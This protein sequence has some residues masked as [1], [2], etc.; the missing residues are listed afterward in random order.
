MKCDCCYSCMRSDSISGCVK[1]TNFL[2]KYFPVIKMRKIRK[3]LDK[4]VT[5][6][7]GDLFKAMNL[8]SINVEKT[9]SLS[10]DSFIKDVKKSID[11][12]HCP[13]DIVSRWHVS[14]CL[15]DNVFAVIKEVVFPEEDDEEDFDIFEEDSDGDSDSDSD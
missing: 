5:D 6:A 4:D 2:Q 13:E 8:S 9:L 10:I 3:S 1:C 14:T 12:I 15:A 7:L 11:E